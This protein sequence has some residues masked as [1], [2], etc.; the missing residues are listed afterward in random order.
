M[1]LMKEIITTLKRQ[2]VAMFKSISTRVGKTGILMMRKT[3][4]NRSAKKM[5]FMAAKSSL[6][7]FRQTTILDR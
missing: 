5:S 1:L 3:I 6:P 7:L 4:L 2:L